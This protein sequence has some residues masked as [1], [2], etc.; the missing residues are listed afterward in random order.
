VAN[1]FRL[2]LVE[3]VASYLHPD[4]NPSMKLI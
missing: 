1:K 3:I 4:R 2:S